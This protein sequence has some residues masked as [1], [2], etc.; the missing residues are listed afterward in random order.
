MTSTVATA[1]TLKE[2]VEL[3]NSGEADKA[4]LICREAVDRN[5][6]DINMVA[7][8]GATLMKIRRVEEAEKIL[9]RAID[10]APSFAKP[11]E[12]LGRL[13]VELHRPEEA[14]TLL[15]NA[16]RLNP[17]EEKA[18]FELGKALAMTGKGK[19]AD[20]AFE[21]SFDLNP[22]RKTLAL[23]AEHQKE[24]RL[25]EAERCCRD[26]LRTSPN[27]VDA[28]RLLGITLIRGGRV[29]EAETQF[30]KAIAIAP[31]FVGALMDLG[32]SLKDQ[33]QFEEAIDCFKQ[34]MR[35]EPTNFQAPFL[36]ASTLTPAALTYE[37]L[38]AYERVL[39]LRPNH[40]GA[41]LGLAH[42][43]K[44]IGRQKEAVQAYRDCI[45]L[46]PNNG[47][48]YWSMA[49]LKTYQ[50]SDDDI[51]T[52]ESKLGLE[53][54]DEESRVNF[55]FA[56]AKAYEDRGEYDRA[57]SFYVDG[58]EG[59]RAL[60]FYDPVQT[61]VTND[62]LIEVFDKS[63]FEKN[64]GHGHPDAA[65]IFVVGLPRS[66]STL[67]EQILASHSM[68]EGTSELP[69]LGQVA[70]S[71]NRNRA[72]GIN[73]PEAVR[74][75]GNT[76]LDRL[77]KDYLR[78]AQL[79]RIEGTPHFV[80]KMPNNFPSIGLIHLILPNAKIIDA[81]RYPLDSCLSCYRQLFARGQT[82]TYDLTDIGEYFLQYQ[83]M[84]DHWHEVLPGRVLTVQY[85]ELVTDFETQVRRLID[86][87][88]LP[89]EDACASFHETDRPVRTASSE[90][91]R[92]PVYTK[93]IHFW[94]NHEQH[95]GELIEVLE[96]TLDRYAQ[97]EPINK[98]D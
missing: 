32:R 8:L 11:H 81:R 93:S 51:E 13:L 39:E 69:Y 86:Y 18:F 92:Q 84:M 19:E 40:P 29:D 72:D 24:G 42:V 3:V 60:E 57:W 14:V 7:L 67:I 63:L 71:L 4:V 48:T 95:L 52:M 75:L 44:T 73:Y 38:E 10:L 97:Y 22:E 43:L 76:H 20:E 30:R 80:D 53:E 35:L 9:R 34:A 49:N 94:R 26:V 46:K 36:L 68:V 2:V 21:K 45:E 28:L 78:R 12:D 23:A 31:D 56:L 54:V 55:L 82:F 41:R 17:K 91:V 50:L 59:R 70:A 90:Q 16:T 27:N 1:S 47:E 64:R 33:N 5:P 87:C 65:P 83:R 77:G 88:D 79:H 98:T 96:P 15:E 62:T 66:G 89:W 37:A 58:N 61:E 25:E 6:E 74:E 85:E